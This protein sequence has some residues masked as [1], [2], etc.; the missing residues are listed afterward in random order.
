MVDTEELEFESCDAIGK[1][2]YVGRGTALSCL[3]E[4]FK[5]TNYSVLTPKN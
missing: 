5:F 2:D 1:I 4:R 3:E